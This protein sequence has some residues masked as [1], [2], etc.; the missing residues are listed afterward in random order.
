MNV[1]STILGSAAAAD[2]LFASTATNEFELAMMIFFEAGSSS[3]PPK[4]SE[5]DV[6]WNG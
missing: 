5:E 6:P 4:I 1:H 2:L 3:L